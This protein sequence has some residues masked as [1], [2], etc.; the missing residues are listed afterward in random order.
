MLWACMLE[1]CELGSRGKEKTDNV[2]M[3]TGDGSN[4]GRVQLGAAI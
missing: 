1:G 4:S 2:H 3:M